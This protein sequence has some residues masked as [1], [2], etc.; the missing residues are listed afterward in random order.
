MNHYSSSRWRLALRVLAAV[1]F[2]VAGC[3]HFRD[4]KFYRNIIPRSL[5]DPAALVAISGVCEIAG[6]IGLLVRPLRGLAGWGLIALL[7]CVFPA[8]VYMAVSSDPRVRGNF[9]SWILWLRLPLQ[10]V[11]IAWVWFVSSRDRSDGKKP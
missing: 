2:V 7:I 10:A 8:N 5:P 3:N 1:F 6:G 11:I 9:P 4:P